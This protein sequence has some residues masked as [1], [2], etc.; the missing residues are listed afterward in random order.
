MPTRVEMSTCRLAREPVALRGAEL[1]TV[2]NEEKEPIPFPGVI[3]LMQYHGMKVKISHAHGILARS[4][5]TCDSRTSVV[6]RFFR[7]FD[8]VR[9]KSAEGQ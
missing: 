8:S 2:S 4:C 1:A 6:A 7:T 5:F 9:H 3:Q